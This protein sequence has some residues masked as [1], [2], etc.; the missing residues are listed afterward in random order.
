MVVQVPVY[1]LL[2]DDNAG[3]GNGAALL[4]PGFPS[5][6]GGQ[7]GYKI[8]RQGTG[9]WQTYN[10]GVNSG[11]DSD[12]DITR[13]GPEV[14]MLAKMQ[15]ANPTAANIY[16]LKF[17]IEESV[18]SVPVVGDIN[19]CWSPGAADLF[20]RLQDRFTAAITALPLGENPVIKGIIWVG[21]ILD[22]TQY[23]F[24]SYGILL[25]V[26]ALACRQVL[27]NADEAPFVI[28]Q[29]NS[30]QGL[31]FGDIEAEWFK[32]I[33]VA[34]DFVKSLLPNIKVVNTDGFALKPDK[35]LYSTQGTID[36]GLA[37]M[38]AING[39]IPP[40]DEGVEFP[41]Y[42]LIG[43]RN[44]YGHAPV[45]G[46]PDYLTGS[47]V[48]IQMWGLGTYGFNNLEAGVNNNSHGEALF[49]PELSLMYELRR[50]HQGTVYIIKVAIDDSTLATVNNHP[51]WDPIRGPEWQLMVNE[52]DAAFAWF[53][54]AGFLDPKKIKA[55]FW[56]GGETETGIT[57]P[58]AAS[59]YESHLR[60]LI[61]Y[62]RSVL[63]SKGQADDSLPFVMAQ[64]STKITDNPGR[65]STIRAAQQAI[66]L[67]DPTIGLYDTSPLTFITST[68]DFDAQSQ[69]RLGTELAAALVNSLNAEIRP[70]FVPTMADLR[71][72]L[73][74]TGIPADADAISMISDAALT[75]REA[76]YSRLGTR[77]ELIMA[78]PRTTN[79]VTPDEH[80]RILAEITEIKMVRLELLRTMPVLFQDGSGTAQQAWSDNSTLRDARPLQMDKEI[81]RLQ[82]EIEENL[83]KLEGTDSPGNETTI[84]VFD[85]NPDAAPPAAGSSVNMLPIT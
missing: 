48:D 60:L 69:V 67:G 54:L 68:K 39:A 70:V 51:A 46:L 84:S 24:E 15:A 75:V 26:F 13:F 73:R 20:D 50:K 32:A 57:E 41:V 8:W 40:V 11:L 17:A 61:G 80:M 72:R 22:A 36:L 34:A 33:R 47:L 82:A 45:I 76:I 30:N 31:A 21:G 71:K 56:I 37:I 42:L 44:A 52:I 78:L 59:L 27:P 4:S 12:T 77:I 7:S 74:L 10:A 6:V 35:R 55:V 38:D 1:L 28:A 58:Y 62:L 14:S 79:P 25:G 63:S 16:L 81:S 2:G 9:T 49:G 83:E 3:G 64:L 53:R 18:M 65:V 66:Y 29:M 19:T 85:G 5:Y 43:G 23:R